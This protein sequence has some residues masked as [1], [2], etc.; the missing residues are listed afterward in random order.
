[1]PPL[2]EPMGFQ[3]SGKQEEI[4]TEGLLTPRPPK[5]ASIKITWHSLADVELKRSAIAPRSRLF[6][7]PAKITWEIRRLNVQTRSAKVEFSTL[8]EVDEKTHQSRISLRWAKMRSG[9]V[10]EKT[11]NFSVECRRS[12]S[13]TID[14]K[15]TSVS[16]CERRDIGRHTVVSFGGS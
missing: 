3:T 11:R 8:G 7:W 5:R 13:T 2:D 12:C 16:A 9:N 15:R 1:M 10:L 4:D 14:E 6:P